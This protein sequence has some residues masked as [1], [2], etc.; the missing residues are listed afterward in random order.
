[1]DGE[2]ALLDLLSELKIEGIRIVR[3]R[4]WFWVALHY[5]VLAVTFGGQRNFLKGYY[6]TIGPWIGVPEGWEARSPVSRYAVLR[7]ERIHV[8]QARKFGFGNA[9][10]GLPLFG[11][12]YLLV[13]LPLGLAWCRWRFERV[14]Y[15]EGIRAKLEFVPSHSYSATRGRLI[16]AAVSQLTTGRYGWTATFWPGARRVGDWFETMVPDRP[17]LARSTP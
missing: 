14:A 7:H 9:I 10:A 13:P 6:T 5:I 17:E 11:L 12:L 1:M 16:L 2:R 8:Q 15:V 4:G 3:K